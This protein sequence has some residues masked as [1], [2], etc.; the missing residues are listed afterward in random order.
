[1]CIG[2]LPAVYTDRTAPVYVF[3]CVPAPVPVQTFVPVPDASVSSV[4]YQY[5]GN[6]GKF[7]TTGNFG[8]F[9][10]ASIPAG[11]YF[12]TSAGHFGKFGTPPIKVPDT[13]VSSVRRQHRSGHFGEFGTTS[14]PVPDTSVSSVRHSYRYRKYR[15]RTEH[16]L[17]ITVSACACV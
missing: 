10:T 2:T 4:R 11:T 16:T 6:F 13:S 8:K 15:Y 1:M 14:I 5:T 3:K 17:V 9:G 7:G 12:R